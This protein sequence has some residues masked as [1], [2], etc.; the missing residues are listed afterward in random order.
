MIGGIAHTQRAAIRLQLDGLWSVKEL[1]STLS[2]LATAYDAAVALHFLGTEEFLSS[3]ELLAWIPP[4]DARGSDDLNATIFSLT[5]MGLNGIRLRASLSAVPLQFQ[6][7][8]LASPGSMEAV[9]LVNPLRTVRTAFSGSQRLMLM[10]TARINPCRFKS[11]N[12][13][14]QR[15]SAT[16]TTAVAVW[17]GSSVSAMKAASSLAVASSRTTRARIVGEAMPPL[18]G[19]KRYDPD[20]TCSAP[21]PRRPGPR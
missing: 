19:I 7:V 17:P 10:P 21:R 2:N 4:S 14:A 6:T 20:A 8:R 18:S 1:S 11:S 9:G 16:S 15:P 12:F 3:Q 5:T 13:F